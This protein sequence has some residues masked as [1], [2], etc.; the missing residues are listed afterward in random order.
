TALPLGIAEAHLDPGNDP[1]GD[2]VARFAR[3]HGP[4]TTEQAA[5]RLALGPAVVRD[6]L[7]RLS[8]SGR[9]TKGEF[10]PVAS[11]DTEWVDTEV[12]RRLRN[13]SLAAARKQVEP[14]D[15]AAFARFLPAWQNVGSRL[16]GADG[17]LTVVEQL[18]GTALPASAWESLVL[19]ARVDDYSPA[20]LDELTAAGEVTWAGAGTLPGR[21]GWIRL[22]P[23]DMVWPTDDP[24]TESQAAV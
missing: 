2:L 20:M 21:D 22:L 8:E 4:F 16:R 19:P 5:S 23:G 14:V 15:A 12:L 10:L 11:G 13:R 6:A 24:H 18:A 3:T 9:V 17:V 7:Q 1:L